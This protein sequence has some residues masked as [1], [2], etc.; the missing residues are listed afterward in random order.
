MS[1][2]LP[3]IKITSYSLSPLVCSGIQ[4]RNGWSSG[5]ATSNMPKHELPEFV[6]EVLEHALLDCLY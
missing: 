1:V 3:E 2:K 5:A 6:I 4:Q